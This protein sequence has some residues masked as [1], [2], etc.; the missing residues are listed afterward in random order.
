MNNKHFVLIVEYTSGK[1]AFLTDTDDLAEALDEFRAEVRNSFSSSA[2][3]DKAFALPQII[4]AEIVSTYY[5][6]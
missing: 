3:G 5:R 6:K 1:C 4:S 2:L